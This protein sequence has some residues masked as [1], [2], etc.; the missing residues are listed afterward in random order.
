MCSLK[1]GNLIKS[2]TF[3]PREV[4]CRL[5]LQVSFVGDGR[6]LV[7]GSD[8]GV[9]YIY[10]RKNAEVF[11]VLH[12]AVHEDAI[13]QMVLVCR[14]IRLPPQADG[15]PQ[16][17]EYNDTSYVFTATSGRSRYPY[18]SVWRY[19]SKSKVAPASQIQPT[20]TSCLPM[21]YALF[22]WIKN[23]IYVVTAVALLLFVM[24]VVQEVD[25]LVG[26]YYRSTQ[27][28]NSPRPQAKI[29]LQIVGALARIPGYVLSILMGW[30]EQVR[31]LLQ[32]V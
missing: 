25:A 26:Q 16:T 12:H 6:F 3:K 9:A 30:G 1:D 5:P 18:I 24:T 22:R 28:W 31:V 4:D 15:L 2:F 19:G 29:Q 20:R 11:D 17:F 32:N 7:G 14:S 27:C 21:I 8:H 23:F 13:V 10:E